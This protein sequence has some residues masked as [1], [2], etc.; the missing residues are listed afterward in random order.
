[1]TSPQNIGSRDELKAFLDD[2]TAR[3]GEEEGRRLA[4]SIAHR[5]AMRVLP[6]VWDWAA[7]SE[8]ARKR[9]LTSL[10]VLQ[11]S[12]ISGVAGTWPT[13]LIKEAAAIA[14]TAVALSQN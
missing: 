4:V 9:D 5:A 1:M 10:P 11:A 7:T 13:P 8:Y 3:A 2:L 14:A 6:L 12:L